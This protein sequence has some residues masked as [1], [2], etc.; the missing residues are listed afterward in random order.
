M[1]D[2]KQTC[3]DMRRKVTVFLGPFVPEEICGVSD[4]I[5]VDFMRFDLDGPPR[6]DGKPG[7]KGVIAFRF[8]PWCG[9]LFLPGKSEVR[10]MSLECRSKNDED[11][12]EDDGEGWKNGKTEEQP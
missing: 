2:E 3:C 12:D 6:T 8:C 4:S 9:K 7:T 1:S 5:L 10:L 11:E